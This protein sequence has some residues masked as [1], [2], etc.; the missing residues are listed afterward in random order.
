MQPT[1]RDPTELAGRPCSVA[2]ALEV[3]GERWALLAIR[4]VMFGNHGFNEIARRTGAPRDR[5]AS[6]LKSLVESA[7]LERRPGRQGYYLTEA[8]RDLAPVVRALLVWG[9]R[10]ITSGP[11]P[12]R[13][14]HHDHELT[15]N[16]NCGTCGQ[17]VHPD[18]VTRIFAYPDVPAEN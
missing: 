12:V 14:C 5:L 7:V 3:V 13:L 2:A 11:P 8:G 17:P 16:T 4:E 1:R 15:L 6:R 10:W 18:D 9:D